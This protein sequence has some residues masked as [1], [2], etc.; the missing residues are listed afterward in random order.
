MRLSS[1]VWVMAAAMNSAAATS[2]SA[3]LAKPASAMARPPLVPII[4]SGL[5]TV[6]ALPSRKA[7]RPMIMMALTS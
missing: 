2:A 3:E 6:G 4:T 1:P 5:A 7:I